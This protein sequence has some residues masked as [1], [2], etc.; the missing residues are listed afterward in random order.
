MRAYLESY[1]IASFAH[2]TAAGYPGFEKATK[3]LVYDAPR[4]R[5]INDRTNYNGLSRTG[6]F[7]AHILSIKLVDRGFQAMVCE[8]N[9]SLMTMTSTGTWESFGT[10][11]PHAILIDLAPGA[12]GVTNRTRT[13]G[14]ADR[15]PRTDVFGGW[16]ITRHA[17]STRNVDGALACVDKFPD[18]PETRPERSNEKFTAP[19]PTLPPFPG[20]PTC[21][22]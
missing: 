22:S 8:G 13:A 14:G 11:V 16:T 10:R 21:P 7:Y 6:T 12:D 2:S 4:G 20:W 15:A 17:F 3:E 19:Y 1:Y 5:S 9:Y 18:R